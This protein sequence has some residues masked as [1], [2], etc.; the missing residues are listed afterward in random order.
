VRHH[1]RHPGGGRAAGGVGHQQ[2]LHQILLHR[3]HQ[4]L[5]EVH[6]TFPAVGLEL[7]LQA[8]VGEPGGADRAARHPQVPA[9]LVGQLR[10]G[11]PAENNDLRV[12]PAAP[13]PL[14]RKTQRRMT[15]QWHIDDRDR[16]APRQARYAQ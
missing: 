14:N 12:H 8:V 3:R 13:F 10:M 6:V 1:R 2:Q 16:R 5:N 15:Q 11:A 7:H 9:D 4:R